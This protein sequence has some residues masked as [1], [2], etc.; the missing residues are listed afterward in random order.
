MTVLTTASRPYESAPEWEQ[1]AN[2]VVFTATG[3]TLVSIPKKPGKDWFVGEAGGYRIHL[4]YRPDIAFMRSNKAAL[5]MLTAECIKKKAEG[6]PVLVYAAAK[7]MSRK[8]LSDHGITFCQ[9]PTPSIAFLETH[10]M[11]LKG[12][13]EYV[14]DKLSAY[15][16]LL[17]TRRTNM[18]K[19]PPR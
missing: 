13:Q 17:S 19:Q 7:F 1:V 9:L 15:L 4:I 11:K 16:K 3:Q 5:D 12:Y 10:P 18:R 6:K 14:L 2:Y 8:S